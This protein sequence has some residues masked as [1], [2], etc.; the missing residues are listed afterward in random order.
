MIIGKDHSNVVKFMT[1]FRKLRDLIDDDPVGLEEIVADDEPIKQLCLDLDFTATML[2]VSERRHPELF[3]APADPKFIEDWR[4]F[5][6]RFAESLAGIVLSD[7]GF[8]WDDSDAG[9]KGHSYNRWEILEAA[10]SQQVHAIDIVVDFANEQAAQE[11]REFPDGFV[12]QIEDGAAEWKG[13]NERHGVDLRGVF[14]RRNLVP[15]VLIPRHV[16]RRYGGNDK[17]SL[18]ELLRQAHEAFVFGVHYAALALM[19]SVWN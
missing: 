12:D 3:A 11:S 15:F 5:E 1:L 10:A 14:R 19:R 6:E 7:L 16:S 18:F 8:D 9:R 13:L 17:F 4:I 2:S